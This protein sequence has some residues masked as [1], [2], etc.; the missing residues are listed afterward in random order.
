MNR[1]EAFYKANNYAL[2]YGNG[3]EQ[4]LAGFDYV[5]VDP[6]GQNNHSLQL[7]KRAGTLVLAYLSVIEIQP[8]APE[9]KLLTKENFLLNGNN[10]R[11][12]PAYGNLMAD[13]RSSGWQG[14]LFN[15]AGTLLANLGYD[16]LFLDT[17]ADIEFREIP[18]EERDSLLISAVNFVK[19]LRDRFPEHIIIQN[20]GLEKL[21]YWTAEL[22]NGICW[23]NPLCSS[24]KEKYWTEK[25]AGKLAELS[26][27]KN[28]KIMLLIENSGT[29]NNFGTLN[30]SNPERGDIQR[31]RFLRELAGK[32]GF[33]WY[34]APYRYIGQVNS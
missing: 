30:N 34:H 9:V 20:C 1:L 19:D 31:L 29:A 4:E 10:P 7:L 18:G 5:I 23:E 24:A 15:K 11:K 22:V 2:F 3:R 17:I 13:L 12:N 26:S 16:G 28:V 14:M 33:L 25:V 6:S 21:C 32:F 27:S 8:A